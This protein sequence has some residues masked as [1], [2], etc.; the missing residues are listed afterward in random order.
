MQCRAFQKRKDLNLV[1]MEATLFPFQDYSINN[2]PVE[3]VNLAFGAWITWIME[4]AGTFWSRS[5]W[6]ATEQFQKDV[7]IRI[8][9]LA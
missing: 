9:V 5:F 1:G 4:R 8:H 6:S 3:Q 2:E 7:R